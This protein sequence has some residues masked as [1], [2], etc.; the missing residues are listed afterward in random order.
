MSYWWGAVEKSLVASGVRKVRYFAAICR[1]VPSGD[2]GNSLAGILC[3]RVS[4]SSSITWQ[5]HPKFKIAQ[6]FRESSNRQVFDLYIG[7][8]DIVFCFGC[9]PH[10][11]DKRKALKALI[12]IMKENGTP[13]VV[14]F[15][16]LEARN[17]HHWKNAAVAHD[18]LPEWDRDAGAVSKCVPGSR[19][20]YRRA[21][22]LL[23]F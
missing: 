19:P 4:G 6:G 14:H 8:C 11:Q 16:S 7:S 13:A 17:R 1:S 21:R 15:E 10:F 18:F 22:I 20:V 9:V 5:I 23:Y 2:I 12:R 3:N